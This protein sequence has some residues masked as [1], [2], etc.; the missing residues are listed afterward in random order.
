MT[1][2][3][4]NARILVIGPVKGKFEP[5]VEKMNSINEKSGPFHFIL[6]VGDFFNADSLEEDA[7]PL[8]NLSVDVYFGVGRFDLP[9][10]AREKLSVNNGKLY[11]KV[12]F[13][14]SCGQMTTAEGIKVCFAGGAFDTDTY[15]KDMNDGADFDTTFCASYNKTALA[16]L[17]QKVADNF[18]ESKAENYGVD[19][20][21]TFDWPWGAQLESPKYTAAAKDNKLPANLK[22]GSDGANRAIANLA[23]AIQPRYHFSASIESFFEREPYT[24]DV[25]FEH[26]SQVPLKAKHCTRFLSLAPFMKDNERWYY[27]MSMVPLKY[28]SIDSLCAVPANATKMPFLDKDS[29]KKR[30]HDEAET[31]PILFATKKSKKEVPANYVC[32]KCNNGGHWIQDCTQTKEKAGRRPPPETYTCHSCGEKGHW[33]QDCKIRQEK[34]AKR[35]SFGEKIGQ[36]DDTCWFCPP[37]FSDQQAAD[38]FAAHLLLYCSD[39]AYVSL[40]KGPLVDNHYLV[41]PMCHFPS[42]LYLRDHEDV[43][44][45]KLYNE[46]NS[47]TA[48]L[49]DWIHNSLN[50]DAISFEVYGGDAMKS[51]MHVCQHVMPI[52]S[53]KSKALRS[54]IVEEAAKYGWKLASEGTEHGDNGAFFRFSIHAKEG[55][56]ETLVFVPSPAAD[57]SPNSEVSA[58]QKKESSKRKPRGPSIQVGRFIL[59]DLLEVPERKNWHA[60]SV[61]KEDEET[62]AN[63]VK[64]TIQAL[65]R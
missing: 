61:A 31:N 22:S 32:H 65:F 34:E 44:H 12:S 25:P 10:W 30:G 48:K 60:C 41:V 35:A 52:P 46:L 23:R 26:K 51:M 3:K 24:N 13:L 55:D 27:A 42:S 6:C 1:A 21:V 16:S 53:E 58:A 5:F 11:E 47:M 50:Q 49:A 59:A 57:A 37:D 64:E 20:L 2:L 4:E 40:A 43:E 7:K 54:S 33:I 39:S 9:T 15:L 17:Q 14:G 19:V 36:K 45:G 29:L 63:N 62:A 18:L 28:A 38:K 56:S 8:E